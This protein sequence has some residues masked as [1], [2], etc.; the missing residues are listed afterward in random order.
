MRNSIVLIALAAM[1]IFCAGPALA[2]R[3]SVTGNHSAAEVQAGCEAQG[4]VYA[5]SDMGGGFSA[6][7]C[8]TDCQNTGNNNIDTDHCTV[9]C[10]SSV[11]DN[12]QGWVPERLVQPPGGTVDLRAIL[13]SPQ[14]R[15]VPR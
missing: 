8:T 1:G 15:A 13:R 7:G 14:I 11:G 9:S 3:V 2:G 5:E 12:R 6:Y 10:T 4:G